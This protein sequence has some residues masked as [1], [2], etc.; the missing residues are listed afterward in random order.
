MLLPSTELQ[1]P[2]VRTIGSTTLN[3]LGVAIPT[4]AVGPAQLGGFFAQPFIV[5]VDYDR[6]RAGRLFATITNAN[7]AGPAAGNVVLD[8]TRTRASGGLAPTDTVV[9]RTQAIVAT[10]AANNW[11]EVEIGSSGSPF[12]PASLFNQGDV[13]GIRMVR[14]GPVAGDTWAGTLSLVTNLRLRYS[15]L[16]QHCDGCT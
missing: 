16:C 9:S 6:T 11:M 8:V 15:R 12:F 10:W 1:L 7:A 3:A 4:L 2:F 14:N 5:P 13:I